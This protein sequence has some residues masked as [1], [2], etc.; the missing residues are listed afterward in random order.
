ME[1]SIKQSLL[2]IAI[3]LDNLLKMNKYTEFGNLMRSSTALFKYAFDKKYIIL[4]KEMVGDYY[5]ETF[6][7]VGFDKVFSLH[8]T[9]LEYSSF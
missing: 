1:N 8:I 2:L 9:G 4:N 7:I 5:E 6:N 3:E